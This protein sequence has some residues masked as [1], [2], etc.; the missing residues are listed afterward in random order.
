MLI[1]IY[2]VISGIAVFTLIGYTGLFIAG[3][4]VGIQLAS[5]F[6]MNGLLFC[7]WMISKYWNKL[8]NK[9]HI[10][11]RYLWLG[12]SAIALYA[13]LQILDSGLWLLSQQH[14]FVVLLSLSKRYDQNNS[15]L[16]T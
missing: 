15:R 8:P 1:P 2:Y 4:D 13:C 12:A 9:E 16:E 14:C 7:G 10:A 6:C 11:D 5:V 3:V